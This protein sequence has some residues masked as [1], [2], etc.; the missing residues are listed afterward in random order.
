MAGLGVGTGSLITG[1][2]YEAAGSVFLF[3]TMAFIV[4]GGFFAALLFYLRDRQRNS[5]PS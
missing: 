5:L 2:I 3:R 4:L 1:F